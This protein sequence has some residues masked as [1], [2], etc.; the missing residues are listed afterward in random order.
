MSD[1]KSLCRTALLA[2][3]ASTMLLVSTDAR[4]GTTPA[5]KCL[6]AK[7]KAAVKKVAAKGKCWQKAFL[8][9]AAT[10]DSTCLSAAESKFSTAITK[11]E[12]K[13]G[14][15][16]MGDESAIESAAD[17]CVNS[18]VTV[19]SC[20]GPVCNGQCMCGCPAGIDCATC[21][22]FPYLGHFCPSGTRCESMPVAG[23]SGCV[24]PPAQCTAA[25]AAQFVTC[26]GG[27]PSGCCVCSQTAEG[28]ACMVAGST[29]CSGSPDCPIS[30]QC[31]A[32]SQCPTGSACGHAGG[33]TFQVCG[34]T[35]SN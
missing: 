10:A 5:A 28:V 8:A 31:T 4:A 35:C 21:A 7:N 15:A 18:I 11:A 20:P 23:G 22:S 30:D 19:T 6:A 26:G 25:L 32:S 24:V 29:L 33:C 14:C 2:L 17:T 12:A 13:G 16:V 1:A 9:G 34:P 27:S 3:A